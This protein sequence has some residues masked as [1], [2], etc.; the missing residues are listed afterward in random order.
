MCENMPTQSA[1][2]TGS[3]EQSYDE[4]HSVTVE[5]RDSATLRR[6][7]AKITD[8]N[9]DDSWQPAQP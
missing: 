3:G 7:T 8:Y 5:A 1:K 2:L 4:K 9:P 6:D